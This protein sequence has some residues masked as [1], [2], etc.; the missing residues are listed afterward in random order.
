MLAHLGC[1][2]AALRLPVAAPTAAGDAVWPGGRIG[3]AAGLSCARRGR[4]CGRRRAAPN[5]RLSPAHRRARGRRPP[6]GRC[7]VCMEAPSRGTRLSGAQRPRSAW[8]A[9]PP[10]ACPPC[11][12]STPHSQPH[13]P[14]SPS[15]PSY[16]WIFGLSCIASFVCVRERGRGREVAGGPDPVRAP[17]TAPP[18]LRLH[19]LRVRHRRERSRQLLRL[20]RGR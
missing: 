6:N 2:A 20:V 11:P 16:T 8:G 3:R 5:R 7:R 13:L 9:A 4:A 10:R 15:P 12:A 17:T 19:Q 1:P 14:P 18:T